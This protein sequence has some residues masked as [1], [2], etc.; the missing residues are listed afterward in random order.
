MLLSADHLNPAAQASRPSKK[1][2]PKFI[3]PFEITAQISPVA[4]R[5]DLKNL[6]QVHPVFHVSRLRPYTQS[7]DSRFPGRRQKPPPPFK[8]N[9]ETY[10]KVESL[11]DKRLRRKRIEY[12]VK[13]EGYPE[14]DA[15]WEPASNITHDLIAD[16]ESKH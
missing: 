10:Y 16:Y 12:L 6:L 14:Y 9:N 13:W 5:L 15:T 3:G 8:V 11:L 1:L 4:F 2:Q 7:N